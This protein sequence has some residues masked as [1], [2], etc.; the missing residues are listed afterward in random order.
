MEIYE[1]IE[2]QG[3]LH[4]IIEADWRDIAAS[5]R[6]PGLPATARS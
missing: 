1:P 5:H 2:A 6:M 4:M 3:Q